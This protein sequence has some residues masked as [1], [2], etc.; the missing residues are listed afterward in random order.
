[1]SRTTGARWL[2]LAAAS[3]A[4]VV[5]LPLGYLLVRLTLQ[6]VDDDGGVA[7]RTLA[8]AATWLALARTL[9][10]ATASALLCVAVA[11]PLAW[12]THATD[13][14]GRRVLRVLL[15][16]PLAIP[17]YVG[18]Y[19]IV[20]TF[21]PGGFWPVLDPYTPLGA[22]LALGFSYPLVLLALTAALSRLD[23]RLWESARSLGCSGGSAFFRVILPQLRPALA[24]GSLLVG[25]YAAGDFGAVSLTRFE[26]LSYLIYVRHKSLFDR[27]EA[28]V[29]S[30]LL[31]VLSGALA[32]GVLRLGG[33]SSSEL[34]AQRRAWPLIR[35]G[36]W[37]WPCALACSLV[38]F[39]FL[40]APLGVI[41]AWLARGIARGNPTPWPWQESA[42]SLLVAAASA[43]LLVALA[44]VPALFA[45]FVVR[46]GATW[47]QLI[48]Y[49]GYALPGI[50]VALALVALATS[51]S[52]T[53][54]L[55]QTPAL[56]LGAYA[57]RFLP[58]AT[59]AIDDALAAHSRD[60]YWAAR[61]LGCSAAA[62]FARVLLPAVWPA[63]IAGALGVF[64]AVIK[65]LPVT[66]LLAPLELTTLATRIWALTEDAYFAAAS[67]AVLLL[68][69]FAGLAL[70][71]R[72]DRRGVD[73]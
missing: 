45:R 33:R 30:L 70:L 59:G 34:R 72:P 44:F 9:G 15:V 23:P 43:L 36:A 32:W 62:A 52:L 46:A 27:E 58:L 26:S 4:A 63:V 42:S 56:L 48:S 55:Y 35:L 28:G 61:S 3:I 14:P 19:V 10:L 6:V 65:E 8:R 16:L 69:G 2:A 50:V 71:L 25:L 17:S 73:S 31:V 64:I 60:L 49:V 51:S 38:V 7:M 37:R 39:A 66:L 54:Q 67:P 5:A 1:M 40:I 24:S 11:L 47:L 68:V 20:A 22:V 29:L 18:G 12:L 41:I 57:I 13:L 21:A 53:I